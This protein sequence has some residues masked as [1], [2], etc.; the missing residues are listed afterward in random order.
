MLHVNTNR[1]ELAVAT[2]GQTHGH[3]STTAP[4]SFGV[5]ATPAQAAFPGPFGPA[6]GVELFS[7]DGPRRILY[8]GDGTPI[9]PGNVSSTGGIVLNKPDITAADGGF[10][11]GAGDFTSPFFGTSAAAPHAAAIVALFKASNPTLTQQQL[12]DVLFALAIDI[13]ASGI[14]RDSGVGIV[15]ASPAQP[16][17]TFAIAGSTTVAIGGGSRTGTVT[18]SSASC[19]W[20]AWSTV[21]WLTITSGKVGT[22]TGA[23]GFTVAPNPGPARAGTIVVQGGQSITINQNGTAA[24]PF[25]NVT[26]LALA[27]PG[28]VESSL[29]VSSL[30]GPISNVTVSLHVTHTWDDDLLISLVGPDNTTVN[31]STANGDG[32]DDYGSSCA[33]ASRT[34]FSDSAT[35]YIV[36]S[37]APFVGEFRP[38]Q[39]LA[40]FN[41]KSGAAANGTWRLRIQDTFGGDSGELQCWSLHFN[42]GSS[43][44]YTVNFPFAS[45][46]AGGGAATAT[47]TTSSGCNWNASS[48]ASWLAITAGASGSGS[49]NVSLGIQPN[50]TFSTRNA[51][52]TIAGQAFPVTQGPVLVPRATSLSFDGDPLADVG[53]YRHSTGQ[54]FIA[55]SSGVVRS[56]T[57]GAPSLG[58]MPV[59]GDYDGDGR[60]D[61][62]V[63]RRSTGEWFINRSTAGFLHVPWGAP[64]LNDI[65][66]PG[67]YDGDGKTDIGVYRVNT[68]DWIIAR[69]SNGTVL[70]LNWGAPAVADVPVP[71]DFDGDGRTDIG[72]FRLV[73]GE[74][75]VYQ[76]TAGYKAMSWGAASAGD[77]PVSGDYDGDGKADIGV[78]RSS[79]GEWYIARSDGGGLLYHA[80][81]VPAQGD[82]TVFRLGSGQWFVIPSAGGPIFAPTWGAP[83]FGDRP[84]IY[85]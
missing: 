51:T 39:A 75:F 1:G 65:P 21:S 23:V 54:W 2:A 5:A 48:N 50:G 81:G 84:P 35:N 45:A 27:D 29:V 63:Y 47:V 79:T 17:C 82:I 10:V 37:A 33:A 30:A 66:V 42:V 16:G 40:A 58:D 59:A 71:A 4:F 25:D 57:W 76:S 60:D 56:E 13:E 74:W 62:G 49:G 28:T 38:E 43:C 85:R 6:H 3:N 55:Q 46:P 69:S 68:G 26:P 44:S 61:I 41:G 8:H 72:V 52:V 22:G 78:Y 34:R 14:D 70:S 67:D 31:L 32:G 53:V 73:T 9:T 36:G 18:P 64:A 11:S 12:K 24:T 80:W 19:N 7:S 20:T 77:I 83:A 15:M